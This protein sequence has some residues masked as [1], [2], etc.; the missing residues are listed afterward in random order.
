MKKS[1]SL[2]PFLVLLILSNTYSQ[3]STLEL[4]YTAKYNEQYV[5]LDSIL[6]ENLT[7]GGDTTLYAPDT[8]LV[9]DY[10]TNISDKEDIGQNSFSV[11]QNYP[12]PFKGKT[13]VNLYLPEKEHIIITIRDIL[14]R[15]TAY[16]KNTLNRGNH[17]FTLYPGNEKY[18]LFT[19]T[20]KQTSKTIKMLNANSNT[21]YGGK[22]K[23]VCN[24]NEDNLIDYRSQKAITDFIFNLGDQLR[25][26]G[27]AKTLNEVNGSDVIEDAPETNNIYEFE[28]TEGIPCPTTPMVTY[29]GQV[30]N[31]VLI[32][33]QCWLKESLNVGTMINGD[34][35][36]A[37]NGIIE[38]Y[39]YDN[40]PVHCDTYG[41]LYQWNEMMQYT[42]TPGVQGICPP[43]WHL[44]TDEE[45]KQLEGEVDAQYGY[46]D[47]EWDNLGL[48]G[49]DA[50]LNLKS[51]NGWNPGGS[52][53]NLYGFTAL[54]GGWQNYLGPF[55]GMMA[56]V[57]FW[58][59]SDNG[60][61]S[62][63][64]R[65]LTYNTDKVDRV[66]FGKGS[67]RYVRCLKGD[68]T[69]S[70]P[71]ITTGVVL[72]ITVNSA[73]IEGEII[74]LG[75]S[76]VTQHGHCWSIYTNPT[77]EDLKTELGIATGV[78]TFTSNLAELDP[79]TTYYVKAYAT[80]S[81]GTAYGE[82]VEFETLPGVVQGEPCP[83]IPTITYEG[84]V[85][86]TVLIGEQCWL[87]ESLNVGTMI[88]GDEEMTDN[89]II[90]KFCYDNNPV[91]CET[92]GGMY[93]WDEMMQY[94][95]TPGVQGI[96]PS[97]W[98]LP[99]DEEW[100]QL[101]GEVDSQYGYPDP[102]WDGI[103][104]RGYDAGLNLKSTNGWNPGG[105]GTDLYGFAILPGGWKNHWGPFTGIMAGVTYW[106]SSDYEGTSAWRRKLS[107]YTDEIGR[108]EFGQGDA[109]YVRCLK[110]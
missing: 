71:S 60:G 109:R 47:P 102:E 88:D 75:G 105:S 3:K 110:D 96:C 87:K 44:P 66:E 78:G 68:T 59:S 49:F 23:I 86:N 57:T 5:P 104:W 52:G 39:C 101:E 35:N 82:E 16:Y 40:N 55:T 72:N 51:T 24:E 14:G 63:W 13:S 93:Q 41:A 77:I 34:E 7:Q 4:T 53:T 28:I 89:G 43:G 37:D 38:K 50:G 11:S 58:T 26:T 76:E 73:D 83:D 94:T 67:G 48:R 91:H 10:V 21:T 79:E 84:Q 108:I 64:R 74:D 100:K 18:Y 6:I 33:E 98:H 97:G 27:Y 54:A 12:N 8:V 1:M 19:V 31:T 61:T 95:T 106:T 29:E 45:W 62:A 15:K 22:C 30:Y 69:I 80:N 103:S 92:Y 70:F 65:R 85:Y 46:P 20:G 25:Y 42:T 2:L 107:D 81:E 32:G 56:G 9:L 17:T 90:E 36:M 99:T